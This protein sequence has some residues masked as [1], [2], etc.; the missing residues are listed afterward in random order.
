[1]GA[2]A[3]L[4]R[5]DEPHQKLHFHLGPESEHTVHEAELVGITLALHLIKAEKSKNNSFAIGTDNQ[6]TL[7]AFDSSMRKPAHNIAREILRLGTSL[8]KRTRGKK[9]SLTLRWTA[10]HVGIA[11]NEIADREARKA[12]QGMRTDKNSLPVFLKRKLTVNPSAVLQNRNAKI[13]QSWIRDWRKSKKGGTIA[14]I[15]KNTPSVHF[16]RSISNSNISRRSAS[17]VTQL[18]LEHIPLNDYLKRIKKVD[19]ANCPACGSSRETVKHFLLEC[20][21]YAYERWVLEKR[22]RKRH[23]TL[24]LENLLGD[25]ESTVPLVNFINASLRFTQSS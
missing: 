24:T 12:A 7:E 5:P 6:A 22:L 23:K 25:A 10:G 8:Q 16:L 3:V 15:D 9:Y 2:A 1:V 20:P 19:K 18:L 4:I 13:K 14:K 17:L 11:G 21:G